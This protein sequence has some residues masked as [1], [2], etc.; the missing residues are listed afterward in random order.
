MERVV[1]LDILHNNVG[2]SLALGDAPAT[3]LTEAFERSFSVGW[4]A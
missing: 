3:E 4:G 1:R 2:A